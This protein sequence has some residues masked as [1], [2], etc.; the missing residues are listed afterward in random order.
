VKAGR[1]LIVSPKATS[2]DVFS[3]GRV[4]KGAS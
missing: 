4:V 3:C 2:Q 1:C